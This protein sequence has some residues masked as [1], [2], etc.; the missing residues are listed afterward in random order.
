MK[1]KR[2]LTGC[3][4]SW[5]E[6]RAGTLGRNLEVGTKAEVM[7]EYMAGSLASECYHLQWDELFYINHKSRKWPRDLHKDQWDRNIFTAEV[8]TSRWLY[9]VSSWQKLT[10]AFPKFDGYTSSSHP[11]LWLTGV[12]KGPRLIAALYSMI[13]KQINKRNK[14]YSVYFDYTFLNLK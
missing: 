13:I 6:A 7:K 1:K 9:L 8:S 5:R 4:P 3:S 10:S 2:W 14:G 12:D 11:I